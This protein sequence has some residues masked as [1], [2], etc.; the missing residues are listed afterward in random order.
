LRRENLAQLESESLIGVEVR[1]KNKSPPSLAGKKDPDHA[2]R[3]KKI[4]PNRA[5]QVLNQKEEIGKYSVGKTPGYM[6]TWTT[7]GSRLQKCTRI[8]EGWGVF[9]IRV[10]FSNL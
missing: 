7:Y 1:Q 8:R 4:K 2:G 10:I 9:Y 3:G 6:V 5:G